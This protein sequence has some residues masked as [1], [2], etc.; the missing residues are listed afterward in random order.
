MQTSASPNG[1]PPSGRAGA[2]ATANVDPVEVAKFQALASRWWDPSSEFKPLHDI[3][4]LRL[5]WIRKICGGSILGLSAVDVGCGGGI[6]AESMALDGAQVTGI[7]LA[8]KPLMVAELHSLDSG[9]AVR[10]RRSPSKRWLHASPPRGMWLRAWRC[11]STC[12]IRRRSLK[13]AHG[14]RNPAATCSSRPSTAAPSRSSTRSWARNTCCGC[15][16]AARTSTTSSSSRRSCCAPPAAATCR[17][18]R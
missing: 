14:S 12:R 16:R 11:W 10:T 6:L 5:G 15:C 18:W 3:N 7:D 4:P 8:D 1:S 17:S 9:V 13:R 2:P